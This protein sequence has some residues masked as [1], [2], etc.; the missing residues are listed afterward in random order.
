MYRLSEYGYVEYL[1]MF[2]YP[3]RNEHVLQ[4][5]ACCFPVPII[6]ACAKWRL[7]FRGVVDNLGLF[8]SVIFY[9]FHSKG[10]ITMKPAHNLREC[11]LVHFFG[12]HQTSNRS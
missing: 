2:V 3:L 6:F 8:F 7:V 12:V 9:G 5:K 10:F 11:V 4:G 1:Y